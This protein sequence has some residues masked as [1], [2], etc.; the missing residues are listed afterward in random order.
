MLVGLVSNPAINAPLLCG[1]RGNLDVFLGRRRGPSLE[2][3]ECSKS[4]R[5]FGLLRD[6]VLY[7]GNI[8]GSQA[9]AGESLRDVDLTIIYGSMAEH[10]QALVKMAHKEL[11]DLLYL[12][13]YSH[14]WEGAPS[15][16]RSRLAGASEMP[17]P[18]GFES[19]AVE[20]LPAV[21]R[22]TRLYLLVSRHNSVPL[23]RNSNPS[24]GFSSS[25]SPSELLAVQ[26]E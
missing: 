13:L 25:S 24:A 6:A 5:L 23:S 19:M 10:G 14:C 4:P 11:D 18:E 22:F 26:K 20:L 2:T 21:D 3:G 12:P 15:R 7:L 16:H 8:V 1:F 17:L 9:Q